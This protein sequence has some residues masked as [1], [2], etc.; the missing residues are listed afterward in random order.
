MESFYDFFSLISS[1]SSRILDLLFRLVINTVFTVIIAR[2]FY[3]P[4]SRRTDF[5][6]TYILVG[7]GIFM[8]IHLMGDAKLKTGI[9]MGLFAIFCIMRYRTESVPIREMTYLFLIIAM[10]AIN[11]LAWVADISDKHPEF[12]APELTAIIELTVTNILFVAVIWIAEGGKWARQRSSKYIKYD[13]IEL[14]VPERREELIEDL[15]KRTGLNIQEVTVGPLDFLKDVALLKVY[16][17]ENGQVESD[18]TLKSMKSMN[19]VFKKAFVLAAAAL[20]AQVTYAQSDD[21]GYEVGLEG[22][23][24]IADNLKLELAA[25]MRTQ[26]NAQRIDRYMVGAGLSYKL[27]SNKEKTFSVKV[28]GGFD[29]LRINKLQEKNIKYFDENDGLVENENFNVNVGDVKGY[30]LTDGYWQNRYRVN[31]G[32]Q[33][34]YDINK[35][36]SV[37]LRETLRYNHYCKATTTRTKYRV[38]EEIS[39]KNDDGTYNWVVSPYTY[40]D[41]YVGEDNLDEDGNVIGKS[42]NRETVNKGKDRTFLYSKLTVNYDIRKCPVDLFVSADYG[43]G[44]TKHASKWKFTGGVDYKINKY[45][46]LT[47]SYRYSTDGDDDEG[48]G[49]LVG[50]GYKFDF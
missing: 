44:L 16:Y 42:L 18:E 29:Y 38:D 46:K 37:S 43:R 6:F 49:H 10:A 14:I 8:L 19:S 47:L 26:D 20:V 34:S 1:D 30:N 36:W 3:F 39:E 50:L 28:N 5:L 4:K 7:F 2:W 31:V 45:N 25:E 17:T 48:N 22:E 9:A 13:K 24:K 11:G 40:S 12:F 32:V 41:D 21:F 15:K 23:T 35:R 27:F 33:V